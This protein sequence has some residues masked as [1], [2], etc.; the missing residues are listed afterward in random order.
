MVAADLHAQIGTDPAPDPSARIIAFYLPQYHPIPENDQWWGK[1]FTDWT[2]VRR[3]RPQ[4]DGHDQPR[5]PTTLGYYDLRGAEPH[6][7]QAALARANG[8]AG[9]CY[10]AYWFGGRR[11][12]EQPLAVVAANPDLAMPYAICWANEPWSRR[13]DGSEDDVLV[14]QRHAPE[15]D[16]AFIDEIGAHLADARYLRIDGRPLLLVYRAGLLVDP[17]RTTDLLR[18]RAV[19]LGLGELYLAMVQS[20]D[21][22]DPIGYGF[23]AAVE[24]PP[25]GPRVHWPPRVPAVAPY[26]GFHGSLRDY[27]TVISDALSRPL[28]VHTWFR[29]VMPGWDNT[30]RRGSRAIVYAGSSPALFRRWLEEVLR[31]TYLF[32]RPSERL[33]FI[34]AWN[35]WAEGAYLEPDESHGSSYLQAVGAALR[36]THGYATEA[37]RILE[38]GAT[39]QGLLDEARR[40]W[41][42]RSLAEP[43][44]AATA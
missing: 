5:V 26:P 21:H 37:A 30:A 8:I 7:A 18:E 34:N 40:T 24:F 4:F 1:G 43:P 27:E 39:T 42:L 10:Y 20:F 44:I 28:P 12:L 15:R 36:S 29:G 13:W 23:D 19:Q 33:V 35:E 17:L 22:W 11:L 9:F 16:A 3:A 32:R 6:F 2:N 25:H 31:F 14:E 38:V 41:R